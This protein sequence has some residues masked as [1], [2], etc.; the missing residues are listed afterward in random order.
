M[1][2]VFRIRSNPCQ[3][4]NT[5]VNVYSASWV[6]VRV[7]LKHTARWLQGF[8]ISQLS[9]AFTSGCN[10][11]AS[12]RTDAAAICYATEGAQYFSAGK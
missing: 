5:L 2:L 6:V 7:Y 1:N 12:I 11:S 4:G 8:V 3:F 10:Q 9:A